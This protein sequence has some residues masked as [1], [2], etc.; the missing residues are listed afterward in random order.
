MKTG[1]FLGFTILGFTILALT[2]VVLAVTYLPDAQ[3]WIR[4]VKILSYAGFVPM[5]MA[6]GV[7]AYSM[8]K[9]S[10]HDVKNWF[11]EKAKA[12]GCCCFW[13][14]QTDVLVF[15]ELVIDMKIE[16]VCLALDLIED[17]I[18]AKGDVK[19]EKNYPD[20]LFDSV[21]IQSVLSA[22]GVRVYDERSRIRN[23][24]GVDYDAAALQRAKKALTER[25]HEFLQERFE[26]TEGSAKERAKARFLHFETLSLPNLV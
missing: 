11:F 25:K 6:L 13:R 1:C 26:D 8:V 21:D 5:S 14:A 9:P 19:S 24:L 17:V 4:E 18:E 20:L 12:S 3:A 7:Y 10:A 16:E 15:T 23:E 22:G 2:R